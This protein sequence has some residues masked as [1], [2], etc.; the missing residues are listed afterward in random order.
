MNTQEILSAMET[1]IDESKTAV[2]AT[3]DQDEKPHIRWVIPGVLKN[4][5]GALY[6][7]TALKFSK[8]EHLHSNPHVEM[9]LQSPALDK[10]INVRGVM[11]ILENPSI[12][13]EVLEAIG[14]RLAAFWKA[15][16]SE[17]ELVV[18]ELVIDEAMYYTPMNGTR[19]TVKFEAKA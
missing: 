8:V 3:V 9:M 17:G 12:R 1:I 13:K 10:V 19:E 4:R 11:N 14:S 7:V 18:L 6:T 16:V 15:N 2:L 5:P